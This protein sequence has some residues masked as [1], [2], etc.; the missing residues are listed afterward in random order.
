MEISGI[1]R[2]IPEFLFIGPVK[3][4]IAGEAGLC[5]R[6][7]APDQRAGVKQPFFRNVAAQ[8]AAGLFPEQMHQIGAVHIAEGGDFIYRK[9]VLQMAVN[10][11]ECFLH[12]WMR[13]GRKKYR[14]L[15]KKGAVQKNQKLQKKGTLVQQR[16]KPV[17]Q[18]LLA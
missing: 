9:R 14:S 8:R 5:D 17:F 16:G 7:A 18:N 4:G 1:F 13:R 12:Q 15:G 6:N 2:R 10:I 11:R 3:R